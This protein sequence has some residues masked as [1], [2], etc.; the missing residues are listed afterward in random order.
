MNKI[1]R[2]SVNYFF[3]KLE[4]WECGG[5]FH[6]VVMTKYHGVVCKKCYQNL[7]ESARKTLFYF[8]SALEIEF[9]APL[10][11][12]TGT[13]ED[14]FETMHSFWKSYVIETNLDLNDFEKC[15]LEDV[16][17]VK[18]AYETIE[19]YNISKEKYTDSNCPNKTCVVNKSDKRSKITF[20]F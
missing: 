16:K 17:A 6:Q 18:G 1:T 4:C 11:E 13:L 20:L 10:E 2:K 7:H 14:T 5:F 12:E 9:E 3:K 8:A 15:Y 19:S